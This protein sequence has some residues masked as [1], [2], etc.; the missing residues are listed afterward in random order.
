MLKKEHTIIL[1]DMPETPEIQHFVL[2][3]DIIALWVRASGSGSTLL[4][5]NLW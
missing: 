3:G 4:L 2:Q 1:M 5:K